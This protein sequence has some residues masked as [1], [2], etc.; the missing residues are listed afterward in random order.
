MS[1][2]TK[3]DGPKR[4]DSGY[5]RYKGEIL[6]R[7]EYTCAD[8]GLML[9]TP[10]KIKIDDLPLDPPVWQRKI[11]IDQDLLDSIRDRGIQG[12]IWVGPPPPKPSGNQDLPSKEKYSIMDGNR[13]IACL[14]ILRE[15]KENF[16]SEGKDWIHPSVDL[17]YVEVRILSSMSN[18]YLDMDHIIPLSKGG[19]SGPS[20]LQ[21]LCLDCHRK[22]ATF[23]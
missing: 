23:N 7:D 2:N 13:R 8:C 14:R 5:R 22:K 10:A 1:P 21:T 18:A 11:E 15:E 3:D 6:R 17:E 9:Y 19:K 4:Y 12:P 16:L 20:N